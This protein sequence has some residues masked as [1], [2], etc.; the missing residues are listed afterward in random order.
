MDVA[1][2][3]QFPEQPP[4]AAEKVV[5]A[6]ANTRLKDAAHQFEACLMQE[7]LHPLQSDPMG[8]EEDSGSGG[9]LTSFAGEALARA[10]SDRGGFGIANQIMQHFNHKD[11][12]ADNP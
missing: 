3:K 11:Y 8:S 6:K 10:I 1:D 7:L 12:H 5:E 2:L 4:I 9:A